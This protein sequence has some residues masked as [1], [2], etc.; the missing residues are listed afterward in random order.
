MGT[1]LDIVGSLAIRAVIILVVIG[2]TITLRDALYKKTSRT[3]TSQ[4][5][6]NAATVMEKDIRLAGYNSASWPFVSADSSQ[7]TFLADLNNVGNVD[8][9]QYLLTRDPNDLDPNSQVRLLARVV[10]GQT[11]TTLAT[12]VMT[13][14]FTYFDSVGVS[15]A[16]L[17]NV[18]SVKVAL[19]LLDPYPPDTAY[20]VVR[21]EFRVFPGNL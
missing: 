2:L 5:L 8:T 15:T 6:A 21:R 20:A 13:L 16:N 3:T 10:D 9:V 1:I 14:Q 7:F 19:S 17:G 18:Q 4:T 11:S 12:G